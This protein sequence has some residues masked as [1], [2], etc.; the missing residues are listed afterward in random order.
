[1]KPIKLMWKRTLHLCFSLI[2]V[3]SFS[4]NLSAQP[5]DIIGPPPDAEITASGSDCTVTYTVQPATFTQGGAPGCRTYVTAV[6]GVAL[7]NPVPETGQIVLDVGENILTYAGADSAAGAAASNDTGVFTVTGLPTA[8]GIACN[9][10]IQVSLGTGCEAIVTP[11]MVLEGNYCYTAYTVDVE[12][13]DGTIYP[14]DESA[15]GAV[16]AAPG[17]YTVTVTDPSG[18]SCWSTIVAEDKV[19]PPVTCC[20]EITVP[21]YQSDLSPLAS[22]LGEVPNVSALNVDVPAGETIPVEFTFEAANTDNTVMD[23]TVE[24]DLP[25]NEPGS[26]TVSL[27]SP[28]MDTVMI[29]DMSGAV[30]CTQPNIAITLDDDAF[31]DHSDLVLAECGQCAEQAYCGDYKS[32]GFGLSSLVGAAIDGEWTLLVT[33][34]SETQAISSGSALISITEQTSQICRPQIEKFNSDGQLINPNW[35]QIGVNEFEVTFAGNACSSIIATYSDVDL[36]FECTEDYLSGFTREW[37][38]TATSGLSASS[39][40]EQTIYFN[41]FG[42]DDV[43]YPPNFDGIDMPTIDCADF[44]DPAN[45]SDILDPVTGVV[46]YP[47]LEFGALCSNF[48]VAATDVVLQTC[49]TSFKVIRQYL[50][51][52]WCTGEVDGHN[53]V[54][55]VEDNFIAA[56]AP[57]DF[58]VVGTDNQHDCTAD[59]FVDPLGQG[60]NGYGFQFQAVIENCNDFSVTVGFLPAEPG[61]DQPVQGSVYTSATSLGNGEWLIPAIQAGPVWVRYSVEDECGN[62]AD[63]F[64]EILV[65]DQSAPNA[66][67]LEHTIAAIGETGCAKVRA[68]SF[69]N[70]SFDN[71]GTVDFRARI[72]NSGDRYTEKVEF[73]C[74][75]GYTC[76]TLEMV[77][78]VVFDAD[79]G[80]LEINGN[81]SNVPDGVQ[82]SV[83][84]VEIEFQDKIA[85]EFLSGPSD[86]TLAC[87]VVIESAADLA[88][89]IDMT[90]FE[91][92]DNCSNVS[93]TMNNVS[94]PVSANECGGGSR[95]FSWS[96]EDGCGNS[97]SYSVGVN[98]Q[99]A[100]PVTNVQFPFNSG[101]IEFFGCPEFGPDNPLTPEQIRAQAGTGLTFPTAS[102][103]ACNSMASSF[104]DQYFPN[105][106]DDGLCM[107]IVRTWTV[108]DWCTF[109]ANSNSN[110]GVFVSSQIITFTDSN[111]PVIN[112]PGPVNCATDVLY[113]S[114]ENE[115]QPFVKIILDASDDC[116]E[117]DWD[118]SVVDCGGLFGTQSFNSPDISGFYTHGSIEVTAT[119]TD[120]CGNETTGV[121]TIQI[122]DCKAPTPYCLGEI[123][124]VTLP[125]NLTTEIWANDFELGSFDDFASV[126]N[127]S[128]C[129]DAGTDPLEYFFLDENGNYV[130]VLELSCD[131]IPNGQEATLSLDVWVVDPNGAPG[132]D[133]DFCTVELILQDNESEI[134]PDITGGEGEGSSRGNVHMYDNR[135]IN[136]SVVVISSNQPEYPRSFTTGTDGDYVFTGLPTGSSYQ[137]ETVKNTG[138]LNGVSTLDI[139]LIQ[140]HLLSLTSFTNPYQY[141]AADANNSEYVSAA[142]MVAIRN[143]ILEK[144]SDFTNGQESWRF[145]DASTAFSDPTSPFPYDEQ[146]AFTLNSDLTGQDFV[147]VKIGDVSNDASA[148]FDGSSI[149]EVR[150]VPLRLSIPSTQYTAGEEVRLE[151]TSD[152]FEDIL[153]MQFTLG[154]DASLTFDRFEA[155][156]VNMSEEFAGFNYAD[157]GKITVSWNTVA[158]IT[159]DLDD[160]LFTVVY[161][162][163]TDGSTDQITIDDSITSDEAYDNNLN[164]MDIDLV[165][166]NSEVVAEGYSLYQNTPNPFSEVSTIA[167]SLPTSQE[168]T[169]TIYDMSGRLLETFSGVYAKGL[170][171]ITVDS[172][173]LQNESGV[174]YYQLSTN[175][176]TAT[177]KMILTN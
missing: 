167:F 76:G 144:T 27:V 16:I 107:K 143:V 138:V 121:Y 106:N 15:G 93:Q 101:N 80:D 159:A 110:D 28:D 158:A 36:P 69:D 122:P 141:I 25:T 17:N 54:I 112:T 97:D 128:A 134:C 64:F 96:V 86:V 130:P 132:F 175:E 46:G 66:V 82:Y 163:M 20:D 47:S 2:L 137:I 168:A 148:A 65:E 135:T 169:L 49:G 61:T 127:C 1:M 136:E 129:P 30:G 18:N 7:A 123:V 117:L 108:I 139:L 109:D 11:D 124:T 114:A 55:K 142:D 94:F 91:V 50:V 53:Q 33:N 48:N 14:F 43:I 119:V 160:V 45:T 155:G 150:G 152:N 88:N 170:N 78:F 102:D 146:I 154:N 120:I 100:S 40:C 147:A 42:I 73:C 56:T 70:G 161:T 31:D 104:E 59:I 115:C 22:I 157:E 176:F 38:F 19:L 172:G 151:V 166:G 4:A 113:N 5:C 171:E 162:A 99:T 35:S 77:E 165:N 51:T 174:F 37:T 164:V 111:A 81:F 105:V 153:G 90:A 58:Q 140:R 177:K 84:M 89:Y 68:E 74:N 12:G 63:S 133:R 131:D 41:K 156:L 10:G 34:S 32:V 57:I 92:S 79:L 118:V 21:C 87:D 149:T 24:L 26:I 103:P 6:N 13:A 23:I 8:T 9:D 75:Q 125:S 145:V 29:L 95:S 67:C 62:T 72:M 98:F 39:S 126:N 52:D 83:C 173:T 116:E 44:F 60:P 71:C 3:S 85:P